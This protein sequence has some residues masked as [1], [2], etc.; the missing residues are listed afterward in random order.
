MYVKQAEKCYQE[1]C[2]LWDFIESAGPDEVGDRDSAISNLVFDQL[3]KAL[4][5][6]PNH[7]LAR[8][9]YVRLMADEMGAYAEAFSEADELARRAPDNAEYRELRERIRQRAKEYWPDTPDE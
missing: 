8:E 4:K 7:L 5:H 1:A 3:L 9:M 2:D 6:D